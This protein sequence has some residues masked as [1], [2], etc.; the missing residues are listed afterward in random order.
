MV[1]VMVGKRTLGEGRGHNKKEAE[2]AAARDALEKVERVRR[3]VRDDEDRAADDPHEESPR[4]G[5][6]RER[7]PEPRAVPE[8]RQAAGRRHAPAAPSEHDDDDER[9]VSEGGEGE[10]EGNPRGGSDRGS[11][12]RRNRRGGRNRHGER[13][14]RPSPEGAEGGSPVHH[15]ATHDVAHDD[16]DTYI[17]RPLT[18]A[19]DDVETPRREHTPEPMRARDRDTRFD[20]AEE[21]L[22]RWEEQEPE[23]A[24]GP[25]GPGTA[26]ARFGRGRRREGPP[27]EDRRVDVFAAPASPEE[28]EPPADRPA[29]TPPAHVAPVVDVSAEEGADTET[30]REREVR[31]DEMERALES[32]GRRRPPDYGRRGK[33]R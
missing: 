17:E 8:P 18:S 25:G 24:R 14:P 6:R 16:D 28:A 13:G 22:V 10:G 12:R 15:D 7:E 3:K 29:P 20:A 9:E 23:R 2:Q 21:P 26:P 11:R 4:G 33:R 1:E 19:D 30:D 31:I 27:A 5:P 32:F